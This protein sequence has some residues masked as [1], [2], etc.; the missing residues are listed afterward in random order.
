M[1][2]EREFL[3]TALAT[4]FIVRELLPVLI[5]KRIL[6]KTECRD[7]MDRSLLRLEERQ[8]QDFQDNA[9]IWETA[10]TFVGHLMAHDLRQDDVSPTEAACAAWR[11]VGSSS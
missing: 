5:D 6:S 9:S 1:K 4:T 11:I 8:N 3:A 10:R 7:I 2:N